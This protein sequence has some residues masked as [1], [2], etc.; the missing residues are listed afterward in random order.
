MKEIEKKFLE[1][2]QHHKKKSI[3]LPQA[4]RKGGTKSVEPFERKKEAEHLN[5]KAKNLVRR[6][7]WEK[8]QK[9]IREE[10]R[11][12][13]EEEKLE[14]IIKIMQERNEYLK[15]RHI[16]RELSKNY[17]TRDHRG[18]VHENRKPA[19]A[20]H[21]STPLYKVM[22]KRYQE[23]VVLPQIEQ[24]KRQLLA[25]HEKYKPLEHQ[26]I[27]R[28]E[29]QY[30]EYKVN[31]DL[32]KQK[33]REIHRISVPTSV[34]YNSI[35]KMS[36]LKNDSAQ[37]NA[38][39]QKQLERKRRDNVKKQYSQAVRDMFLPKSSPER[40]QIQK[41]NENKYTQKVEGRYL[42]SYEDYWR[43][44]SRYL[45]KVRSPTEIGMEPEQSYR[46]FEIRRSDRLDNLRGPLKQ[47]GMKKAY[48]AE[49]IPRHDHIVRNNFVPPLKVV[50]KT[51]LNFQSK[52]ERSPN[53]ESA[54]SQRKSYPN[55]L[56]ELRRANI[57]GKHGKPNKLKQ[58][59]RYLQDKDMSYNER[60]SYVLQDAN[61][62]ENRAKLKQARLMRHSADVSS[63]NEGEM[64][65][66]ELYIDSIKA[67][68]AVLNKIN[69]ISTGNQPR[70][71]L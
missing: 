17:S 55:Y 68:L 6:M 21:R 7:N 29:A 53:D 59:D 48:S 11:R 22:E 31:K 66:D 25:R 12:K 30:E 10:Q 63:V 23:E 57:E 16:I 9:E 69:E 35:F 61:L 28:F 44:R 38:E 14:E 27:G 20:K 45:S 34:K 46:R 32:V 71:R 5:L 33:N 24:R 51:P 18:S 13:K 41:P 37:K 43:E 70:L 8:Q 47:S 60:I 15:E 58:W 26:D 56:E 54:S 4:E 40:E 50:H 19:L 52:T 42:K 67:K 39:V 64:S 3:A 49:M 2:K 36:V 1:L 62:L 65:I